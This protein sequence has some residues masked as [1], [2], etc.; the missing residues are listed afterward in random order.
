[1]CCGAARLAPQRHTT[2]ARALQLNFCSLS[3]EKEE[4]MELHK[5][6]F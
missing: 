6:K 5:R 1:M 4:G 2:V 3:A